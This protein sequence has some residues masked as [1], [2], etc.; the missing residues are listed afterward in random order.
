MSQKHWICYQLKVCK[1]LHQ[2][3]NIGKNSIGRN[4]LGNG[5]GII[6]KSKNNLR[7]ER[8]VPTKNSP[9]QTCVRSWKINPVY[10]EDIYKKHG[11]IW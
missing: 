9:G 10:A 4:I 5:T 11:S 7:W 8:T 3:K 6:Q 2:P 1:I